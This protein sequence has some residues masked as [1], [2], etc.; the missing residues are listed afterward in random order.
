MTI[1]Y[2]RFAPSTT[3]QAHLGT[4]LAALLAWLDAK[5]R[6]AK[7]ILRLEDIDK[8]RCKLEFSQQMRVDLNWLGLTFDSICEQHTKV[9]QHQAALEKLASAGFLYPC[10]CSRAQIR[11]NAKRATD[12]GYVYPGT[13]LKVL[14][15]PAL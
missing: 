5:S 9:H 10:M 12:G 2:C 13:N 4:M 11:G 14:L 7:L 8:E 3:G 15:L 6:G 1:E